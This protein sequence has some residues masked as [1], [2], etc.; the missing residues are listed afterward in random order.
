MKLK[1]GFVTNSSST[2]FVV[3]AKDSFDKE[4]LAQLMGI[5]RGSPFEEIAERLYQ[6]LQRNMEPVELPP[7]AWANDNAHLRR[8]FRGR[9]P[10]DVARKVQA[11]VEEGKRVW[12][13]RLHTD[14][15]MTELLFCCD[16]FEWEDERLYV[17]GLE[18]TW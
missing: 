9:V 10:D 1:T 15:D 4:T 13:G 7:G 14:V 16:S 17:N 8:V 6:A 11:A 12:A 5:A 3:I 18:C 2:S